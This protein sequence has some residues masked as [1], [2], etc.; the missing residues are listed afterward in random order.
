MVPPHGR[1]AVRLVGADAVADDFGPGAGDA[2]PAHLLDQVVLDAA[3][4]HRPDHAAVGADRQ[5]GADRPRA[6]APGLDDG[7]Q[8]AR[9]ALGDPA[10]GG[11]Q[12]FKVYAVHGIEY[13]GRLIVAR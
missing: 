6:R 9:Q 2:V 3:A 10:R 13:T 12:N 5:R 8:L 11:F 4:G 7:D 1:Q